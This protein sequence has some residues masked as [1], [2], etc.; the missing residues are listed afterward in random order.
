MSDTYLKAI[1]V[2]AVEYKLLKKLTI[3]D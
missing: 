2:S 1:L 3:E